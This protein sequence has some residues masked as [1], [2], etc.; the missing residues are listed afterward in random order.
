MAAL[1]M[2]TP[3]D[4][5]MLAL[6]TA[7]LC[8]ELSGPVAAIGN[9]VELVGEDDPGFARDALALVADSAR[10]AANLLQF[11]RFAYGF[12]GGS[13]SIGPPPFELAAK[14]FEGTRVVCDY[15]EDV[16]ALSLDRQKLGCNLILVGA[17]ALARGG[18]LALEA[19]ASG[20]ELRAIGEGATLA[21][22]Q[23]AALMLETPIGSLTS[24]AVQP[25]YTALLARSL[26][27]RLAAAQTG[28]GRLRLSTIL[29]TT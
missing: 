24:R 1:T 22:E 5:Q 23:R 18:C 16:R 7:R 20:L 25:C 2:T 19:V 28:P 13:A 8:H 21:R 17:T 15:A 6:L 29:A 4:M 3:P 11:Y 26:G 9:G 27:W 10:R 12:G 14:L